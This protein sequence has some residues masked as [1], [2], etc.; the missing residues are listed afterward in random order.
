MIYFTAGVSTKPTYGN[1]TLLAPT[2]PISQSIAMPHQIYVTASGYVISI[3][4]KFVWKLLHKGSTKLPY[5]IIDVAST[6]DAVVVFIYKDSQRNVRSLLTLDGLGPERI[7]VASFGKGIGRS[8]S[9]N[10]Q[11][12][13]SFNSSK[14]QA[15]I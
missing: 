9:K 12:I 3:H 13:W 2:I 11:R 6:T 1:T 7:L 5:C 4:E 15:N 14:F 10:A 8:Q